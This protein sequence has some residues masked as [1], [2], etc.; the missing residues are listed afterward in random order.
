MDKGVIIQPNLLTRGFY[1]ESTCLKYL[2]GP[3]RFKES[4]V[5]TNILK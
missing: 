4:G 5:H 2:S 3:I 1:Q